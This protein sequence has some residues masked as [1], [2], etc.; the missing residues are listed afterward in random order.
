MIPFIHSFLSLR[1]P[2]GFATLLCLVVFL[3][4][5]YLGA[6]IVQDSEGDD[7]L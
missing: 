2:V 6:I 3:A 1:L 4:G 7:F 5:A